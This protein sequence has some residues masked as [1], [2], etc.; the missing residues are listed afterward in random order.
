[1]L[2]QMIYPDDFM[3]VTSPVA[4]LEFIDRLVGRRVF[5]LRFAL[6]VPSHA[7]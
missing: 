4:A 5:A 1:M 6:P 7:S 3:M 2:G